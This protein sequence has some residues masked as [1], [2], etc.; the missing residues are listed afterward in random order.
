MIVQVPEVGPPLIVIVCV[1][2]CVRTTLVP[3]TPTAI[4]Q[5]SGVPGLAVSTLKDPFDSNPVVATDSVAFVEDPCGQKGD[6]VFLSA[7]PE[8]NRSD[9]F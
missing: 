6:S 2:V 1:S 3:G 9:P 4:V 8:V 5:L 7:T